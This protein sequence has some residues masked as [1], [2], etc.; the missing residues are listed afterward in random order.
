MQVGYPIVLLM[1]FNIIAHSQSAN[2][3]SLGLVLYHNYDNSIIRQGANAIQDY[4][5]NGN[6]GY[7]DQAVSTPL[8]KFKGAFQFDGSKSHIYVL[9]VKSLS[10]PHTGKLSISF[11]VRFNKLK[12]TGE[13]DANRKPLNYTYIIGKGGSGNN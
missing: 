10:I 2:P 13:V 6:Y 7:I 1:L 4:S 11:W 5:G 8:G 12:F 9:N 3:A